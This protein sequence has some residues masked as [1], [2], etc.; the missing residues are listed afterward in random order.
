MLVIYFIKLGGTIYK[1]FMSHHKTNTR[2]CQNFMKNKNHRFMSIDTRI[3]KNILAQH[4]L[5]GKKQK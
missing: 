4:H 1:L 2:Y 3:P 5:T